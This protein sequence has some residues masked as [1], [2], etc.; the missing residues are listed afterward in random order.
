MNINIVSLNLSFVK[1]F[2]LYFAI[3]LQ[4]KVILFAYIYIIDIILQNIRNFLIPPN[5]LKLLF[6]RL[7]FDVFIA[8]TFTLHPPAEF[9]MMNVTP[10]MPYSP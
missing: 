10:V 6:Y 1:N 8:C 3:F 9:H 4:N 7:F 5:N 2:L